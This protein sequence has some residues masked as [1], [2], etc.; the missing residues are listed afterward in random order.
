MPSTKVWAS[1]ASK[2]RV[3]AVRPADGCRRA[4]WIA[5]RDA[6]GGVQ[7]ERDEVHRESGAK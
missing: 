2:R 4:K 7:E 1:A 6:R 5:V 3:V